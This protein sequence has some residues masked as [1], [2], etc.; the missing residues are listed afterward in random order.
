LT[1]ANA[2]RLTGS[3]V[4]TE[5]ES[6]VVRVS[7]LSSVKLTFEPS[8]SG[9]L[10]RTQAWATPTGWSVTI[11]SLLLWYFS[12]VSLIVTALVFRRSMHHSV[13]SLLPTIAGIRSDSFAAREI[14]IRSALLEGLSEA[15]RLATEAY[16]GTKS[17][18][19]DAILLVAV[20]CIV[21][22]LISLL[23]AM[24]GF[25]GLLQGSMDV[26]DAMASSGAIAVA[27]GIAVVWLVRARYKR[28]LPGLK[29]WVA[30][31]E[32]A[33]QMEVS[34]VTP[35]DSQRST[36]EILA[37]ASKELPAWLSAR[38]KASAF[39]EPGTWLVILAL[40]T[41]AW[42]PMVFGAMMLAEGAI[43]GVYLLLAGAGLMAGAAYLYMRLKKRQDSE[44]FTT[45]REWNERSMVLEEILGRQLLRP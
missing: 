14:D 31:L 27:F 3:Q 13:D 39:R 19:G 6:L 7:S 34:G 21:V 5:G 29:D 32:I 23:A 40:V 41:S 37:D 44:E 1:V 22:F 42:S 12:V 35:V 26:V 28:V 25:F 24:S 20:G 36:I 9:T 10:V 4:S 15:R 8:G 17:N 33:F 18:Y 43:E 2:L 45:E 38:R 30:D 11:V 16:E